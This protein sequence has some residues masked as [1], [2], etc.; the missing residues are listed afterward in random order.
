MSSASAV[1]M[2]PTSRDAAM[3]GVAHVCT[4]V[5]HRNTQSQLKIPDAAS[6]RARPSHTLL[7]IAR[8]GIRI[9]VV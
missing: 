3:P 9:F 2:A 5:S 1:D 7:G 8:L 4:R 6:I